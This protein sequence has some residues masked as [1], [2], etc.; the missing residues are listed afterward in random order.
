MLGYPWL[1]VLFLN[2]RRNNSSYPKEEQQTQFGPILVVHDEVCHESIT[3]HQGSSRSCRS[4]NPNPI[5]LYCHFGLLVKTQ[6][7]QPKGMVPLGGG[8]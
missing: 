6:V 7:S 3:G 1:F 8:G 4:F 5:D 2:A